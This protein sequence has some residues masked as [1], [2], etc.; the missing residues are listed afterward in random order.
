[1]PAHISILTAILGAAASMLGATH[2][3]AQSESQAMSTASSSSSKAPLVL[4]VGTYTGKGSEGI[5]PFQL[6]R[7][8]GK[9]TAGDAV[10]SITNP[11]FLA[12]SADHKYLYCCNEI[13]DFNGQKSGAATSFK[14]DPATHA[15][16]QLDQS[17]S[18]GEGP[19][20]ISVTPGGDAVLLANYGSGDVALVPTLP[21]G[22][23]QPKPASVAH[24]TGSSIVPK[25]QDA[26]HAHCI[27][28]DPSGKW[29]VAVDLGIDQIIA[30]KLAGD[31][32]DT[33]SPVIN[34]THPGAGPRHIAFHPGGKFAYVSNELDSTI[35]AYSW[36]SASGRLSEIQSTTT[37]PA[38][39]SGP[40]NYP[41]EVLIHPN[42]RYVYLSNRG[43]D[44]V[45][46]L[47][48]DPNSGQLTMIADEPTRGEFPRGMTLSPGGDFL[49]AANQNS[50]S[51]TVYRV[52]P[53]T[54]KL[55]FTS[56]HTGINQPAGLVILEP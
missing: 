52:D 48:I 43:H 23:L 13:G 34:K 17:T 21:D 3:Y 31:S 14:I 5:Y 45:A 56:Q 30:Y 50:N 16:T 25:R 26:P 51:I 36:D 4:Y 6:D 35:S 2:L 42:G 22:A 33:S 55:N 19:C 41:G 29:A 40:T 54:G 38:N 37:V 32:M 46:V 18:G 10:T 9:L 47:S 8:S 11:S 15:L 7:A 24:H 27:Q 1:M 53:A 12:I 39:Y 49:V 44:S 20:Y 28:P